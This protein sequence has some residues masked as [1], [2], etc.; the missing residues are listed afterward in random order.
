MPKLLLKF[1]A[2]VIKEVREAGPMVETVVDRLGPIRGAWEL[3]VLLCEPRL[4]R[5]D[6]PLIC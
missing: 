2:A 1:N 6:A 5:V 4:Q 3:A